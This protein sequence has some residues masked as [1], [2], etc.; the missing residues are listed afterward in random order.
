MSSLNDKLAAALSSRE[1][2]RIRRRLPVSA[3]PVLPSADFTS[4]DY[5][6]LA[7][8]STLRTAFQSA[9]STAPK[10]LGS[11][12]S[13]LLVPTPAHVALENRLERFF[14]AE[15]ALLFNSGFDA[16]VAFF[17]AIPQ[18]GDVILYDEHI[19]AS[20]HD[21]MGASR[22]DPSS[23]IKFSHNSVAALK[24]SLRKL[25]HERDDL[26]DGRASAFVAVE[27]LYSMDGTFAPLH[28]I[29]HCVEEL[30][31][32]NNGYVIVDEAH[33]TGIY[34]PQGRGMVA[35]LGLEG[36][37]LARLHTFGK[38][39]AGSGAAILTTELIRD[40]LLNYGRP[41]IYTTTLTYANIIG[42]E[43]AFDMLENGSAEVLALHLLD[44]SRY[45]L[46]LLRPHLQSAPPEL[47]CLPG[48]LRTDDHKDSTNSSSDPSFP[49][50][51]PI[52]PLLTPHPHSLAAHLASLPQPLFT[53]AITWP[54]V[55]VGTSRVRVCLHAGHTRDDVKKLVDGIVDWVQAWVAREKE[56]ER[57]WLDVAEGEGVGVWM[58]SKL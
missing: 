41:L 2:R 3:S 45:F 14:G 21:G 16:N 12:G 22:V 30:L 52:I 50:P 56:V 6:S 51:T 35:A 11:G 4:N 31:P 55:P 15:K 42:V 34:G 46:E 53:K 5:L 40:Y 9:L 8:S 37:V 1:K 19:H 32:R 57:Q 27:S 17:S 23:L 36:R 20:V 54:T 39:L 58:E 10:I 25:L 38:A 24:R 13:R 33:A 47:L 48:H 26:R 7:T 44:L 29:V 18:P 43:C 49:P 28:E